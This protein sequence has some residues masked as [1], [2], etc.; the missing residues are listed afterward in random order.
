M[1]ILIEWH[2]GFRVSVCCMVGLRVWKVGVM[3]LPVA[4]THRLCCCSGCNGLDDS[5]LVFS[6]STW[7]Y[8]VTQSAA[9]CEIVQLL[10]HS[11]DWTVQGALRCA[12][13]GLVGHG[14]PWDRHGWCLEGGTS[15]AEWPIEQRQA[16]SYKAKAIEAMTGMGK[17]ALSPSISLRGGGG[18]RNGMGPWVVGWSLSLVFRQVCRLRTSGYESGGEEREAAAAVFSVVG[19]RPADARCACALDPALPLF[20]VGSLRDA[21]RCVFLCVCV[22]T[23]Y[24]AYEYASIWYYYFMARMFLRP[25]L[26]VLFLYREAFGVFF[27]SKESRDLRAAAFSFGRVWNGSCTYIGHWCCGPS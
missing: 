17:G 14:G 21:A 1:Q 22:H 24:G 25:Y 3:N 13:V 26:C 16:E 4:R 19:V 11:S 23:I 12:L 20:T 15:L 9:S 6:S 8:G 2:P 10:R 5:P 18:W 7:C 27:L